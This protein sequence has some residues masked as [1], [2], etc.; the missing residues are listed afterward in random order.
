M[1]EL[2][3]EKKYF[4]KKIKDLIKDENFLASAITMPFKKKLLDM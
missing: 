3:I 2:D 1:N 4:N